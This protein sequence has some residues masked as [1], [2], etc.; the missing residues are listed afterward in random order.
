MLLM[1]R[2]N[3]LPTRGKSKRKKAAPSGASAARPL[4]LLGVLILAA[5]M[6]SLYMWY[7]QL[8]AQSVV[9]N[10]KTRDL[11]KK[12]EE[13]EKV[14]Q[15]MEER[16]R[17]QQILAQQN[18][19]FD[20]LRY[21]KIGPSNALLFLSYVLSKTEDN[22]FNAQELQSQED[23]G[24]NVSWDPGRLWITSF[25][26]E[27][28]VIEIKGQAIEHEDVTE[29]YR[30]LESSIYF[31]DVAPDVQELEYAE[32]MELRYVTFKVVC[33]LNYDLE[34]IPRDASSLEAGKDGKPTA[35]IN[36]ARKAK[37]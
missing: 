18:F 22:S 4:I 13:L 25:E 32:E 35:M 12:V 21:D 20:E 24:W 31:Y 30:R 3:L 11:Q 28:K 29:F 26:E 15:T 10:T 2:I 37:R 5:G 27:D 34:G 33:K 9:E 23:N 17:S 7:E 14:K 1:I 16:E 6:V 36:P 8:E 19:I